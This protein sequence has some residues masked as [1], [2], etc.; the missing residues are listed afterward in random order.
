M[1]DAGTSSSRSVAEQFGIPATAQLIRHQENRGAAAA[2]NTGARAA[3]APHIAF[4]DDDCIAESEWADALLAKFATQPEAAL[5]GEVTIGEPQ[6]ATDRV[7][8]L[9]S[10]PATAEDGSVLR[11]Q[12]ANLAIPAPAFQNLGGFDERFLEAG[13]ED[14]EFCSRW[15]R[16][17]HRIVAVPEAI[18]RH[19][20]DTTL[21]GFWHQHY[22]YGKG[23]YMLYGRDG[24]EPSPSLASTW[25]RMTQAVAGGQ[26][27]Y[28]RIHHTGLVGLSQAAMLAGFATARFSRS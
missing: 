27:P 18:V 21:W 11:A 7:T 12:S 4:I 15:R 3:K 25:R 5:A 24:S 2:R 13:Y 6:L 23:A 8:Q 10:E 26:T 14:Y 20:R 16:A 17:G 9:L 19:M 22:R 1:D 28:E